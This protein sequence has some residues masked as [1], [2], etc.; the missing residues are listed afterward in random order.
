MTR[1]MP[2]REYRPM[3][4]RGPKPAG[5]G[6]PGSS[7]LSK[8]AAGP[9]TPRPLSHIM[10][11]SGFFC[12]CF[13]DRNRNAVFLTNGHGK[14]DYASESTGRTEHPKRVHGSTIMDG[15]TR[16]VKTL[17]RQYGI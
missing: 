16:M 8:D 13:E 6:G 2:G 7:P 14:H 1:F 4:L 9:R 3:S 11:C 12:E 10:I 5:A 15:Y 17:A